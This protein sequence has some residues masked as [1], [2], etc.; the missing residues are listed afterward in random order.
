MIKLN[1]KELMEDLELGEY[2]DRL[3]EYDN[4]YICDVISEITNRGVSI[5][6][7]DLWNWA[8]DNSD[9]I[10]E[11]IVQFGIDSKNFDLMRIF[12]QGQYLQIQDELYSNLNDIIRYWIYNNLTVS[13]LSQDMV[14]YIEDY[15]NTIDTNTRLDWIMEEILEYMEVYHNDEL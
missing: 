10:E 12:M 1:V 14:N 7:Y 4:G 8:K 2:G 3:I 15:S 11:G 9:W 13:E 5:Y 6:N